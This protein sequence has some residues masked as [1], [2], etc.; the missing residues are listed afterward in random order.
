MT[1]VVGLDRADGYVGS[2]L[3]AARRR[4]GSGVGRVEWE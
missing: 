3:M 2:L 1:V 4:R